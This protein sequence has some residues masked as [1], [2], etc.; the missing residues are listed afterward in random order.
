[1]DAFRQKLAERRAAQT[2]KNV[3]KVAAASSAPAP[4]WQIYDV[5]NF[6]SMV[7]Y[8]RTVQYYGQQMTEERVVGEA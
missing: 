5:L 3:Q 6:G 1:M 4:A 7:W 8:V 2:K